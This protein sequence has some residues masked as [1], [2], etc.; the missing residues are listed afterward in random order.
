MPTGKLFE[1]DE[2][3][4]LAAVADEGGFTRA[5]ER[6]R[7]SQPAV[8]QQVRRL[9]ARLRRPLFLRTTKRVLLTPDGEA[10]LG[11]ARAML[12][13]A[14]R[15]EAHFTKATLEGTVRFGLVEDFALIGLASVLVSLRRLH[16][17]LHISTEVGMCDDLFRAYDA[18]RLDLV[19]AKR[20]LGSSRG[21]MLWTEELVWVGQPEL[22][23][24]AASGP[25]PLALYPART[26][27][28]AAVTQALQASGRTWEVL[29]ES[30]SIASLRA[31][32]QAGVGLSAFGSNLLPNGMQ[33]LD[34]AGKLP[35]PG[36]VEYVIE[37]RGTQAATVSFT[38]IVRRAAHAIIA[39]QSDADGHH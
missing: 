16:P 7:L 33:P 3:R 31:A 29:F 13:L 38:E 26:A 27:S 23:A 17:R 36:S 14:S 6:L 1:E 8:S 35:A 20:P 32:V 4:A 25:V 11:Y 30:A 34:A 12:D 21:E 9:E 19:L 2:L 37:Q 5:A 28:R 15:A 24:E 10:M 39:R 22:L 18:G